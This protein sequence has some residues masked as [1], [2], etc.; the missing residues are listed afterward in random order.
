MYAWHHCQHRCSAQGV[1]E[2]LSRC[3]YNGGNVLLEKS[4]C[5]I[6]SAQSFPSEVDRTQYHGEKLVENKKIK[7]TIPCSWQN[8]ARHMFMCTY[9]CCQVPCHSAMY[10][11]SKGCTQ[12]R[13]TDAHSP[14]HTKEAL[15]NHAAALQGSLPG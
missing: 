2:V 14:T 5:S 12:S 3:I 11:V 1:E 13:P 4:S 6:I 7:L 8:H 15:C 9:S 10:T